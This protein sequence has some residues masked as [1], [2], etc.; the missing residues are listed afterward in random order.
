MKHFRLIFGLALIPIGAFLGS[1]VPIGK[2]GSGIIIGFV[3]GS[4]L[5]YL[6]LI[7]GPGHKKNQLPISYYE[8]RSQL[9]RV[10][11]LNSGWDMSAP[12][13]LREQEASG[14]QEEDENDEHIDSDAQEEDEN[15]L[16]PP[17]LR[18]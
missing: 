16:P 13:N 11:Q 18:A 12:W 15:P 10:N 3:V 17:P 7:Y 1:F 6:F 8:S 5:S 2:G 14:A 9:N 4:V